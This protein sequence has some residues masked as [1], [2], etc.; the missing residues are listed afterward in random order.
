[1]RT[2]PK[3]WGRYPMSYEIPWFVRRVGTPTASGRA[4]RPRGIPDRGSR[5]LPRRPSYDRL[6]LGVCLPRPGNP[7]SG[8][9]PRHGPAAQVDAH[10]GEDHP[11]VAGRQDD[12]ARLPNRPVD[13]AE[14]GPH[15]PPRVRRREQPEVPDRLAPSPWV[16]PTEAPA[17]P[18]RARPGGDRRVVGLRLAA[19]QKKLG[20]Q[21]SLD[22][23]IFKFLEVGGRVA[24]EPSALRPDRLTSLQAG[25]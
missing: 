8:G 15:D 5:R 7:R 17:G 18:T 21:S 3:G 1:M 4:A 20:R 16:H 14:G 24:A 9:P 11:P 6:T 25:A 19:H 22:Q 23:G 12:R 13:R 2:T 10:P